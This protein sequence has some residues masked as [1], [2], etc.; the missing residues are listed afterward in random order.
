MSFCLRAAGLFLTVSHALDSDI[1]TARQQ[2]HHCAKTGRPPTCQPSR[3]RGSSFSLLQTSMQMQRVDDSSVGSATLD[4]EGKASTGSV[5]AHDGAVNPNPCTHCDEE[6]DV[7]HN[8]PDF[9]DE[10]EDHAVAA[11]V[12][13]MQTGIDHQR[14]PGRQMDLQHMHSFGIDDED[15]ALGLLDA[16][17]TM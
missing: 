11:Q 3:P 1:E 14:S 13:L 8:L 5:G 15:E 6:H 12:R 7:L 4:T 9:E 10:D 17:T 16:A 2:M